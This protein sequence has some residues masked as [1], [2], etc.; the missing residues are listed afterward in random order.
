MTLDL[1]R[2]SACVRRRR[3]ELGLGIEPAARRAGISK[4]TWKRTERGQSVREASYVKIDQALGWAPGSCLQVLEGNEPVVA[5][6]AETVSGVTLV[7]LPRQALETAIRQ[8]LESAAIAVTDLHASDIRRM[9]E[10]VIEDL[11]DKKLI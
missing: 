1:D 6:E 4:D 9:N 7:S 8:A 5:Q 10:R 3:Q 11:R 2:L